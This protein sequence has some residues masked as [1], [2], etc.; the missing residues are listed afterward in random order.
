MAHKRHD[1]WSDASFERDAATLVRQ[2]ALRRRHREVLQI[3]QLRAIGNL[4]LLVAVCIH[5]TVLLGD[6]D[7][8]VIV[9]FGLFQCVYVLATSYS[10][11]HH[12]RPE[13]KPDLGTVYLATDI[14]VFVLAVYV[15]GGEKSWLLP[16]LCVR[17]ADQLGT[18]QRRALAFA[19]ATLVMHL[20]LVLELAFV[21][22]RPLSLG[23]ELAKVAFVYMLNGYLVLA[24][25]PSERQRKRAV[26]LA[27][28]TRTL[29]EELASKT[30]LLERER[31]RA[32]AA[33]LA[34]S[35]FLANMS[36]EIRTPMNGVLG[37]SELLLDQP[38]DRDQRRMVET[39]ASSGRSLL[40]IVND[41]LDMSKI[42][43]GEL[44]LGR[45]TFDVASVVDEVVKSLEVQA[46]SKGVAL[47]AD[48]C[49]EAGLAVVGDALRLRQ[50][51]TNLVGN[52]LKF[53]QRG[54]VTLSVTTAS[55]S[56]SAIALRFD[57]VDTGVGIGKEARERIFRPFQQ[58]DDSTT[59]EF[60]G[61]GLG[62]SIARQLVEMMGGAIDVESELGRGSRFGFTLA[63]PRGD[64][65]Q[66]GAASR[67]T[68]ADALAQLRALGPH[69]L[70]AEDTE[71]NRELAERML[72]SVGC[73]VTS[74]GD[75]SE[76]VAQL[77][78]TH[79]FALALLDWHMPV[80][81]GVEA[82]RC[83]RAWE[84]DNAG[85]RRIPI[86]AFTASA[87]ADE[88]EHCRRAGMDGVLNKPLTKAQLLA[89]LQRHLFGGRPGS[90]LPEAEPRPPRALLRDSL[91]EELKE[92][93]AAT[94]GG[95]L[96]DVVQ[97]YL[98]N[99]PQRISELS[100]A[101]AAGDAPLVRQ[102]AHRLK[103]SAGNLGVYGVIDS[104]D[105]IERMAASGV[106]ID[107]D[108]SL[109]K[110]RSEHERASVPLG[111]LLHDLRGRGPEPR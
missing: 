17:V 11:R 40:A 42:E 100:D 102:L 5:N 106:L 34:K 97:G 4:W 32:E 26:Q 25:G 18:S 29:I 70:V 20:L 8:R 91:I 28:R 39:I 108:A 94:P 87:F 99:V 92:L 35:R 76:A 88:A 60:G 48:V 95:F 111:A 47:R 83:V 43:A 79:D 63:L 36:H 13:A 50:V 71:I 103:G 78:R 86:V 58:A 98:D 31:A 55:A 10:L 64:A 51:L 24:A 52:A 75:G 49:S 54:A 45:T 68:D 84:R 59:R 89:E 23:T 16:L 12:Y 46:V 2:R 69:V 109:I 74:V 96:A 73:R 93:D 77:C 7:L 61:T 81:D 22:Q 57:V 67:A 3:P 44:R 6:L 110:A 9:P 82:T 56:E 30:E 66:L 53:T 107:A 65:S 19:N 14:A 27:D 1:P 105:E 15:S 62:L 90:L 80:L 33:N 104:L 101:I 72:R 41:V 37:A 21:E 85:A 38:L